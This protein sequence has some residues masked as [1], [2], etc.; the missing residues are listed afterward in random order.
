MEPQIGIR[1]RGTGSKC[2]RCLG[3]RGVLRAMAISGR[4]FTPHERTVLWQVLGS[5]GLRARERSCM[6]SPHS[7]ARSGLRMSVLLGFHSILCG[8][9]RRSPPRPGFHGSRSTDPTTISEPHPISKP[10]FQCAGFLFEHSTLG[11]KPSLD[12][13]CASNFGPPT[14][15]R[16]RSLLLALP[17]LTLVQTI[18]GPD[19]G[20]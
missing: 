13:G 11:L 16:E 6:K 2:L 17:A 9:K 12:P 8:P 5:Q 18:T 3:L 20:G 10:A 1:G 7:T 19:S 4:R 15:H 14:V